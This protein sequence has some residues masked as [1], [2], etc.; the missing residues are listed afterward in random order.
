[1]VTDGTSLL[2]ADDKA[3][4]VE[5]M[6]GI[7]YLIDHPEIKHGRIRVG[8][9]PMRKLVE[10]LT[11][12]TLLVLMLTSHTQWMEANWVN[13]NL[14]VSMRRKLQLLVTA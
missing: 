12:L 4:V 14:K 10:D 8:F 9:T 3:G 2:G 11:S 5:I 1:M 7:K 6:E 13:F